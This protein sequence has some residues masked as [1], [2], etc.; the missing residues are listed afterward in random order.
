MRPKVALVPVIALKAQQHCACAEVHL[1]TQS[2]CCG[3]LAR[4]GHYSRLPRHKYVH[5]STKLTR[6]SGGAPQRRP[7]GGLIS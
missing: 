4:H 7:L 2:S 5:A 3:D 6:D 1:H